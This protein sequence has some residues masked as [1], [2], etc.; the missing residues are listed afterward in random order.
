MDSSKINQ[1]EIDYSSSVGDCS[2]NL[3]TG[4]LVFKHFDCDINDKMFNI[5]VYHIFNSHFNKDFEYNT[6]MGEKWKLNIQQFLYKESNVYKY[7]DELGMIHTFES[8]KIGNYYDT[9]GLGLVLEENDDFLT[10]TDLSE[11]KYYFVNDRLVK[12]VS[13][14]NKSI[15]NIYSYDTDGKIIS[16]KNSKKDKN[17]IKFEYQD[18]LL[19]SIIV[20]TNSSESFKL[21]YHYN[22]NNLITEIDYIKSNEI[23][24]RVLFNYDSYNLVTALLLSNKECVQFSYSNDKVISVVKGYGKVNESIIN[25]SEMPNINE[26]IICGNGSFIGERENNSNNIYVIDGRINNE[27]TILKNTICY[28]EKL[29]TVENDK[30]IKM[31][32]YLNDLGCTVSMLEARSGDNCD[33]RTIEK[34]PGRTMLS[35]GNDDEKV[36]TFKAH[37]LSTDYVLSTDNIMKNYLDNIDD[38]RGK[39]CANYYCFLCDFWVKLT[40]KLCNKKVILKIKE[41]KNDDSYAFGYANLDNTAI[42]S[43]QQVKIQIKIPFKKIRYFDLSFEDNNP[44]NTYKITDMRLCHNESL[45]LCL[46]DGDS[47]WDSLENVKTIKYI[48]ITNPDEYITKQISE[49]I[50]LTD[51]DLQLM[52]LDRFKKNGNGLVENGY[53]M[54]FNDGTKR[55]LVKGVSLVTESNDFW[56][57]FSNDDYGNRTR[58]NFFYEI[59]SPDENIYSYSLLHYI[60]NMNI[61]G[62]YYDCICQITES[63]KFLKN[64]SDNEIS[65]TA[66]Y[67]DMFGNVLMEVNEYGVKVVYSYDEFG[68]AVN[69]TIC[70]D[71]IVEQIKYQYTYQ[72]NKEIVTDECTQMVNEY[73]NKTE[74]LKCSKFKGIGESDEASYIVNNNYKK[75]NGR[76]Y[77]TFDNMN[78][79]NYVKYSNN[80]KILQVFPNNYNLNNNY[81]Y[82]FV[83]S[84]ESGNDTTL[85]YF[86]NG[87]NNVVKKDILMKK[88]VDRLNGKILTEYYR[89]DNVADTILINLDNYGRTDS[90]TENGKI[91]TFERQNLWESAGASQVTKMKD[92]FA[93]VE[94]N[95]E[96]DF[97]NDLK[98]YEIKRD[99]EEILKMEK[100]SCTSTQ[101]GYG[102][103]FLK[104]EKTEVTYDEKKLISPRITNTSY[105]SS[106]YI[107]SSSSENRG[108]D[109]TTSY[110]YDKLGRIKNKNNNVTNI[111]TENKYIIL[112]K[113]INYKYGTF[114][115]NYLS[116]DY[117][118]YGHETKSFKMSYEYN[119]RG[120]I[121]R[122]TFDLNN[123]PLNDY[124]MSYVYDNAGRLLYEK[125]DTTNK[126]KSYSYTNDG[127]VSSIVKSDDIINFEYIKG[128]LNSITYTNGTGIN[129]LFRYDNFGNCISYGNNTLSWE[130]GRLLKNFKY[131]TN[132]I[133][134]KYDN[135]GQIIEKIVNN[136]TNN[137]IT[138]IYEHSKLLKEKRRYKEIR[139]IY[140]KEE[141]IGFTIYTRNGEKTYMYVKDVTNNIISIVDD[142]D[143]VA[144]Y[145]YDAFGNT[146]IEFDNGDGIAQLNPFRWKSKYYDKDILMY[147]IYKRFYAPEICQFICM[148][149]VESVIE[150][151]L[152]LYALNLY[153][154]NVAN[155]I[156]M[157]YNCNSI[158]E[159]CSLCYDPPQLS[160]WDRFWRNNTGK[161]LSIILGIIALI[162]V[163]VASAYFQQWWILGG[164]LIGVGSSL[165]IGGLISGFNSMKNG[166]SFY[167]GF[168]NFINQN[169]S[170][171]LAIE[172][173]IAIV[174]CGVQLVSAAIKNAKPKISDDIINAAKENNVEVQY[175]SKKDF[176]KQAWKKKNKLPKN[177]NGETISNMRDGFDIH[178]GYR[179]D[180]INKGKEMYVRETNLRM[181]VF[182]KVGNAIYELKPN[183]YKAAMRGIQQLKKYN[184]L[185]GGTYKMVLVLY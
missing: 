24:E 134:Y 30:N 176:T 6:F 140:D 181:D 85:Y 156:N 105:N 41:N 33:L 80:G 89:D 4:R 143:E 144:R 72:T 59:K 118:V 91:T 60:K 67:F 109:I 160:G 66:I 86:L 113:G 76:L 77:E 157:V 48:P 42:G 103:D 54:S 2:V 38:Y 56:M 125:N 61:N 127:M 99:N 135:E 175:G 25:V 154:I 159:N 180:A 23:I 13:G 29:T 11:N 32:Y 87:K 120:L 136:D 15:Y 97:F 12:K 88:S 40:Q 110:D 100:D 108:C 164:Y 147:Y 82:E 138:Y 90:I 17:F 51:K 142:N 3:F 177:S 46:T 151:A 81:G 121:K 19:K 114:L 69:K 50:Y 63:N 179:I 115:Q 58:A 34:N 8:Y 150:N 168:K 104:S 39:K 62:K 132:E 93:E 14:Y 44:N 107:T 167:R 28:C 165:A 84:S 112:N 139:Y 178:K 37:L 70:H 102:N 47:R 126:K 64:E 123:I 26:E 94:H 83:Y 122:Q 170:Q 133:T 71:D 145:S 106:N 20:N 36:N 74:H 119:L 124:N 22:I 161:T 52:Y 98:L 183:N 129:K 169:W 172:S 174:I 78:G 55:M 131:G 27:N 171:T 7:I 182:D 137:K 184:Q 65:Y 149:N 79:T 153:A 53:L 16:V 1:T 148:E 117:T 73:D 43:W 68:N 95:Y 155:T 162:V 35:S 57:S 92:P 9:S 21:D 10:I 45:K 146:R 166:D 31:M 152:C 128:K 111:N 130:R 173:I 163:I 5:G 141:L 158:F 49:D 101:Y 96:Y 18:Q 116:Y 75:Y 185:M